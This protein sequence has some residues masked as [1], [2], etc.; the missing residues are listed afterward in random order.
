MAAS[1]TVRAA[2][3]CP[4]CLGAK[5]VRLARERLGTWRW[6]WPFCG[7]LCRGLLRPPLFPRMRQRLLVDP[8]ACCRTQCSMANTQTQLPHTFCDKR[9]PVKTCVTSTTTKETIKRGQC[10]RVSVRACLGPR[11]PTSPFVHANMRMCVPN[12]ITPP[13]SPP[14]P[15]LT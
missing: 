14:Q 9:R 7:R 1:C 8:R 3:T 10:R 4:I 13:P 5:A 2:R 6:S 12:V 15:P 11:P